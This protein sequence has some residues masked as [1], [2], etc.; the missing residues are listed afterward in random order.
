MKKY[1]LRDLKK[2]TELLILSELLRN[3]SI[4]RRELAE[5]FGVTEQAISQ[6]V[7][8]LEKEKLISQSNGVMKPT[9]KGRQ[10]LQERFFGLKEEI[11]D[12]LRQLHLIDTC[13][14]IAGGKIRAKD[15]VGLIMR[16]G[17]LFAY[18]N[19]DSS[20]TGIAKNDADKDE[21]LFVG[22]LE[23]VVDL[24][25]GD[26][27]ALQLPS[28]ALG[29]SRN[30][31]IKRAK[32][33]VAEFRFDEIAAGDLI[34]EIAAA[35]LNR[36]PSIIHAPVQ[37]SIRALSKGLNVLFLGS[38]DSVLEISKELDRLKL[39]SGYDI[40]RRIIDIRKKR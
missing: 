39:D 24:D 16:D 38:R 6:Y 8:E 27:I 14:A 21:E 36:K 7:S 22:S 11:G 2:N 23:G 26:L 5:K 19:I 28:E 1:L 37:A 29:G 10:L 12:I 18:P 34:G 17:K 30:I 9:R 13:L 31:D 4:R 35:K 25:L 32:N 3:P 40:E 15:K 20:S 33:I